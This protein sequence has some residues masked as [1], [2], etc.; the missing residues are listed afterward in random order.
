MGSMDAGRAVS[1]ELHRVRWFLHAHLV[2]TKL[3]ALEGAVKANFDP[4]QPRVPA[5]QPD[6]GQWTGA[7]GGNQVAHND[8]PDHLPDLPKERPAVARARTA[9]VKQVATQVARVAV[10]SVFKRARVILDALQLAPWLEEYVPYIE[11]YASPPRT[12][13]DLQNAVSTPQKGYDVHHIVEQTSAE[14]D[15]FPRSLIDS[16][17]NLVRVP[18]LKHWQITAWSMIPNEDYGGL[19]PRNYLRGKDWDERVK[20]GKRALVQNGVLKP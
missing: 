7:G 20:V 1:A 16:R 17:E 13:E 18:T 2:E 5:G 3:R 15:G 19:S 9:V 12:L 8:P 10:Q 14:Q 6:G 11:A 4:D